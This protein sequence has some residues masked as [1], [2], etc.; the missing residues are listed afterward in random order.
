MMDPMVTVIAPYQK[1]VD[2]LECKTRTENADEHI[3]EK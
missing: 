3:G 2:K 1:F